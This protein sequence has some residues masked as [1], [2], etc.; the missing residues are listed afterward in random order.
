FPLLLIITIVFCDV[1]IGYKV[2]VI[3]HVFVRNFLFMGL[4]FFSLG[5]IIKEHKDININTW[6]LIITLIIG[7]IIT[8]LEVLLLAEDSGFYLGSV[9]ISISSF[10]ICI[11][12]PTAINYNELSYLLSKLPLYMYLMHIPINS[13]FRHYKFNE[14]IND[15]LYPIILLVVTV[16]LSIV[17]IMLIRII[18][19]IKTKHNV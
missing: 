10:I 15:N 4:P 16:F 18:S 7:V 19:K 2:L 12:Y 14:L 1:I 5:V 9:L 6:I 3:S 11:K 8:V 13:V 17:F